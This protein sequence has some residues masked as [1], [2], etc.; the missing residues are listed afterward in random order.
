MVLV[1]CDADGKSSNALASQYGFK[2]F[3]NLLEIMALYP[4][5]APKCMVDFAGSDEK[6]REAKEGL[7]KRYGMTEE[8]FKSIL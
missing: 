5:I 4:E 8:K 6:V 7:L 2:K 3:I 1:E